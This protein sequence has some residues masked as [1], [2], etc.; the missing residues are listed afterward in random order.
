[1]TPLLSPRVALRRFRPA[2]GPAFGRYRSNPAVARYQSWTAPVLPAE[3][4]SLVR[5]F[6]AGDPEQP[7]WFQYAIELRSTG[8]LIGDIGV[9]LHA[10]GMQAQIGFT[11][12]AAHHGLGLATEAVGRLLDALFL[13]HGLHRVSAECDARNAPS[14]RLLA[15]LGFQEEG[16]LRANTWIKGEWTDDRLFGLLADEWKDQ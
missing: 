16:Y 8:E 4:E 1:M 7:G 14:A 13:D 9:D 2:D 11:L 5:E 6:A 3:A 12:A 15:R 10:N